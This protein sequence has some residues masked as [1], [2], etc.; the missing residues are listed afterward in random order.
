MPCTNW[1]T[2]TAPS[3]E[4]SHAMRKAA[5]AALLVLTLL[6]PFGVYAALDHVAPHWLAGAMVLLSLARAVS[7]HQGFWYL[8]AAGAG[9]LALSSWWQGD[10][11]A[12]K[13][14]PVLVNAVLLAVFGW[15]L[16][17]PPS[18]VERLARLQT[19]D[20]PAAAVGYTAR[21]TALWCSFFVLNG[22]VAAYTA[23][24]SSDATWALY[25]GLLA[26]VAMGVL[27]AGEWLVRQHVQRRHRL[28]QALGA[29]NE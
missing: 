14:Y 5:T 12:V 21:V 2:K 22:T 7:T 3:P 4:G 15:S 16:R 18:V 1:S 8:V 20:L 19:P 29:A 10:A 26:Y 27:M 6:Y 23:L 17:C 9:V 11:Q 13:L 28:E 25:N 24:Y